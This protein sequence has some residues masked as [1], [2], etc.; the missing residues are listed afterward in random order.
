MLLVT[1]L[2]N[3]AKNLERISSCVQ[4]NRVV[5]GHVVGLF[6]EPA[7]ACPMSS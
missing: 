5:Q 2:L 1:C 3:D 7:R 4:N 6:S